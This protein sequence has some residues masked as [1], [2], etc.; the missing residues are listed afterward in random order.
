MPNSETGDE[1]DMAQGPW[2][3]PFWLKDDDRAEQ[4]LSANSE[5]GK[6]WRT[7]PGPM[8]QEELTLTLTPSPRGREAITDINPHSF[9][10]REQGAHYWH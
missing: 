5:T 1:W 3:A 2:E 7:G 6:C 8:D 10:L 4:E 9:T